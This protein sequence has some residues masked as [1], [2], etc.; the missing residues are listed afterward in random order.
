MKSRLP[1]S[2]ALALK[3]AEE[4]A[5]RIFQKPTT[6]I[7]IFSTTSKLKKNNNSLISINL[8]ENVPLKTKAL[9]NW[10]ESTKALCLH[11]SE[12]ILKTPLPAVKYHD[13]KDDKYWV[14]GYFCRPCC[15]L[16]YVQEHPGTDTGRCMMWT[17]TVLRKYFGVTGIMNIAPPRASLEKFGGKLTLNEFYGKPLE[18]FKCMH[19]PPFVT[20]AMYAEIT[21]ITNE[22]SNNT[23][24]NL[25]RPL[26]RTEPIAE[27]EETGKVPL[28]LEY[29]AKRGLMKSEEVIKTSELPPKSTKKAKISKMETP[30]NSGEGLGKYLMQ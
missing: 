9:D 17:Q 4:E 14:Y 20:F 3:S 18:T 27:S 1:E 13:A 10:P 26:Q 15:S 16:A 30:T 2:R 23:V 6:K 25:T 24:V 12:H 8:G 28:I 7:E 5:E 11:C 29:L 22:S 19:T 21:K